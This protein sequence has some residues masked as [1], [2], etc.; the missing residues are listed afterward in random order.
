MNYR[1]KYHKC[2]DSCNF[3]KQVYLFFQFSRNLL[4]HGFSNFCWFCSLVLCMVIKHWIGCATRDYNLCILQVKPTWDFIFCMFW[5]V[6][7]R[8]NA[9]KR[10]SVVCGLPHGH[11][12][13]G[14]A[15]C[16]DS[17]GNGNCCQSWRVISYFVMISF[18]VFSLMF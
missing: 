18:I 6:D 10:R 1:Y 11:G 14:K 7:W 15:G 3:S 4:F 17:T 12:E 9:P 8:K 2:K 5:F 13:A 16:S